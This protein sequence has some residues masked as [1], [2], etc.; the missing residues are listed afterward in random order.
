MPPPDSGLKVLKGVRSGEISI[1]PAVVQCRTL[2]PL[3]FGRAQLVGD[4]V[5]KL[6]LWLRRRTVALRCRLDAL[7]RRRMKATDCT[8]S[9]VVYWVAERWDGRR[10]DGWTG[11]QSRFTYAEAAPAIEIHLSCTTRGRRLALVYAAIYDLRQ[12][13]VGRTYGRIER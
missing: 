4:A 5:K 1:A 9:V 3:F 7:T 11:V 12:T 10:V 2:A 8:S 6:L 13:T